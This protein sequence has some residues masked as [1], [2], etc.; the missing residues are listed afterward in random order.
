MR[1]LGKLSETLSQDEIKFLKR[2]E[3]VVKHFPSICKVLGSTFN[4][5]RTYTRT[6]PKG[7][8]KI[9]FCSFHIIKTFYV[10]HFEMPA[11][12]MK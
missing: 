4:N 5:T 7:E 11:R 6:H 10:A 12:V 2:A 8:K 9:K 3:D 1:P